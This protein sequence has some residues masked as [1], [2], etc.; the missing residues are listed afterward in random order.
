MSFSLATSPVP[1]PKSFPSHVEF[2]IPSTLWGVLE[3]LT[4]DLTANLVFA[5]LN[6]HIPGIEPS[7]PVFKVNSKFKIFLIDHNLGLGLAHQFIQ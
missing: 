7:C 6:E 4:A 1:N 2:Y 5:N 3:S